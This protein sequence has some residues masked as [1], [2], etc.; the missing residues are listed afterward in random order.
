MPLAEAP[1]VED[2]VVLG[3]VRQGGVERP[4]RRGRQNHIVECPARHD[5]LD[6]TAARRVDAEQPGYR[7][8][9]HVILYARPTPSTRRRLQ[10]PLADR[11][12]DT[13]ELEAAAGLPTSRTENRAA[14]AAILG[15]NAAAGVL[16]S[17]RFRDCA[18]SGVPFAVR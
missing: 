1:A 18:C 7:I 10:P 14:L 9:G 16:S 8:R 6:R 5:R 17:T 11:A 12:G 4:P 3:H 13:L 15:E 2:E